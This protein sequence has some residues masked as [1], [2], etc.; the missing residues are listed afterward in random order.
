V[1]GQGTWRMAEDP[2]RRADEI[3]AL[4]LGL[5]LGLT[6]I[7]T[8]EMYA[9]GGSEELVGE[10]IDGRRDEVFLVSKVLPPH[11]TKNGTIR[12]CKQ[13]LR[14]L[15]TDRIDLYLLHWRESVSL[16]E[17]I[18]GFR[19][20]MAEGKIRYW[21]VS[22][23]DVDDMKE[24]FTVHGGTDAA[25]DQVL[26]NL[27]R[28]GIEYDLLP[29][30]ANHSIPIMAYSPI[31]QGELPTHP[32]VIAVAK[33]HGVTPAQIALAWVIRRDHVIAIPKA[34]T[35]EHVRENRDA[36]DIQLTALDLAALD[37]AFPPPTRKKPLEVV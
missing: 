8:A 18:A 30:C 37:T 28:R 2:A 24:L 15:R 27:E 13:S 21:G 22:N 1:L 34:A 31:G 25:T 32:T 9:E 36:L 4:R 33:R 16:G 3:A 12:A 5:D 6:L 14:R 23:F 17:T 10:A 7:D 35:V 26:Y 11:A 20:L 19:Q 29:W